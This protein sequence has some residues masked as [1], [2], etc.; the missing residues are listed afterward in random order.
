[1]KRFFLLALL[2]PLSAI[3]VNCGPVDEQQINDE[4][5]SS[6][7]LQ[8]DTDASDSF[9]GIYGLG[10][11]GTAALYDSYYGIG[12]FPYYMPDSAMTR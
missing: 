6:D 7:A 5:V 12:T 4:I 9:H 3:L 1:M 11:T 2:L 8:L 10:Y